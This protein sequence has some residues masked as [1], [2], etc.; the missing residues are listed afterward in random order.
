SSIERETVDSVASDTDI[1]GSSGST[2]ET[3]NS[4]S[5]ATGSGSEDLGG[6]KWAGTGS[7][8]TSEKCPS[9]VIVEVTFQV[10][11][12]AALAIENVS[13]G[14]ARLNGSAAAGGTT[15]SDRAASNDSSTALLC[16]RVD[17]SLTVGLSGASSKTFRNSSSCNIGI[18]GS[19]CSSNSSIAFPYWITALAASPLFS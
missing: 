8:S 3:E 1:P 5:C 15:V 19:G 18:P 13:V 6:S 9:S 11:F 4:L 10:S 12:G 2:A 14:R 7:A 16:M 17:S